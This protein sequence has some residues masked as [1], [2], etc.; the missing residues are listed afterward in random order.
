MKLAAPELKV[1]PALTL[2][3]RIGGAADS[4]ARKSAESSEVLCF[5]RVFSGSIESDYTWTRKRLPFKLP[6]RFWR[7]HVPGPWLFKL[8]WN[9]TTD[10]FAQTLAK[11]RA[12]GGCVRD[13][14][15]T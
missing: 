10:S 14:D 13:D 2:N 5:A 11:L 4:A 12:P 1:E 8:R 3:A 9:P 15:A 7:A 6:A